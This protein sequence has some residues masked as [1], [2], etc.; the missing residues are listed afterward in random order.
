MEELQEGPA[1]SC[2]KAQRRNFRKIQIVVL[3]QPDWMKRRSSGQQVLKTQ[4]KVKATGWE[5]Q[6]R[7]R[8]AA[9][10]ARP[11]SSTAGF[12]PAPSKGP[13]NQIDAY[14]VAHTD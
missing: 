5:P 4:E 14:K 7:R 8:A 2:K 6:G 13:P 1:G 9:S 3:P 11:G 10:T 12:R